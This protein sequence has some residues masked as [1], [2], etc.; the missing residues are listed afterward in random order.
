MD[1]YGNTKNG[2]LWKYEKWIFMELQKWIFMELQK[3]IFMELQK[4]IFFPNHETG[5]HARGSPLSRLPYCPG[6]S[7]P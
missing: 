4:W 5:C 1:F 6:F 7:I 3:W 2:F